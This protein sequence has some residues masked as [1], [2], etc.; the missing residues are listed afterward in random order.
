[1]TDLPV[2]FTATLEFN[3]EQLAGGNGLIV[4]HNANPSG[5]PANDDS[6]GLQVR[7]AR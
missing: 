6:V 4:L 5:I 2:P 7:F 1:M 3:T